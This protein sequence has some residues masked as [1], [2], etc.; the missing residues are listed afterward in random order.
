M[1]A[2]LAARE[3]E[4][5]SRPWAVRESAIG[6]DPAFAIAMTVVLGLVYLVIGFFTLRYFERLA[7]E[8]ATLALS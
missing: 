3:L 4:G 6:G 8:Q 7:R 1:H 2:T 5:S